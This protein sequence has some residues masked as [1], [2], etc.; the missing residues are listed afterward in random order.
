MTT[1]RPTRRQAGHRRLSLALAFVLTLGLGLAAWLAWPRAGREIRLRLAGRDVALGRLDEAEA[2]LRRLILERPEE[3]RPRLLW[4]EVAR[5]LGRITDAEEA[6]QRTVELGLPVELG[7]REF[8]LIYAGQDFPK[9]EGSL[10][11]VL[12]DRPAD[13]DVLR[14]LAEGYARAGRWKEAEAA[15]T[16]WLAQA[17]GSID[18]LLVRARTRWELGSW[19]KAEV[20]FRSILDRDPSS[21]PAHILR[22]DCL[23]ND[24]KV[25][26]AEPDL[27]TARA[28]KPDRP[29]PLVG[30]A[31][32][33]SERGDFD[34]AEKLLDHA[35]SLAPNFAP[36]LSARGKI[37]IARGQ[38]E[39][40]IPLLE[41][42]A[43]LDPRDKPNLRTLAR[44]RRRAGDE[45]GARE[46]E[47]RAGEGD[48]PAKS[49]GPGGSRR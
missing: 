32:C 26:A 22:A 46:L 48:E 30:L 8:A 6:L 37:F 27:V 11:K 15:C 49:L 28:L 29:E 24:G 42:L 18:A 17:T 45:P 2:R 31:A 14:A 19:D 41:R 10:R 25:A 38:G 43:A 12:K 1:D 44:L 34:E 40:A 16:A 9:A 5:R 21:Y 23:L 47:R 7:R 36:A 39:K 33:A 20:D 3:T 13:T 4:V 35:L